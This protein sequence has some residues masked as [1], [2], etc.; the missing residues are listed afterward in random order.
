MLLLQTGSRQAPRTSSVPPRPPWFAGGAAG[1]PGGKPPTGM[2]W[3]A[4]AFT[5]SVASGRAARRAIEQ[6]ERWG[7]WKDS[8]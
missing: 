5:L 6:A 8:R 1:P 4:V 3:L 2:V 7:E